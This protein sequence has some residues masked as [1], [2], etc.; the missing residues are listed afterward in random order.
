VINM[1]PKGDPVG[2]SSKLLVVHCGWIIRSA[3]DRLGYEEGLDYLP[4]TMPIYN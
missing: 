3:I 4:C 2:V 1:T